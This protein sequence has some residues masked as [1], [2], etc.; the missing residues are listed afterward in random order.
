MKYAIIC[1]VETTGL[2]PAKD[3]VVEV[4]CILYSLEHATPVA[5][6]ASLVHGEGNPAER[7]NRIPS[8]ALTNAPVAQ[9]A[10]NRLSEF[11]DC[12]GD[13][14]VFIAHRAEFDRSF[15]AAVASKL[16][17]R[18]PWVCSKFDIEWPLSKPGASCVEMALAHGVPVVSA[19][20]A[21]T[22]C[23]L[24]AKTIEAVQGLGHDVNAMLE[25][26]LRPKATFQALVSYDDREKA[27]A[28][29]FSWNGAAKVWTRSMAAEDTAALPFPVREVAA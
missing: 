14:A 8:N 15:I 11:I 28:A 9:Y 12:A 26:A 22:D 6:F 23:M 1:D 29:G 10:W 4:G 5:S 2:D 25:R 7:I 20:R 24:V 17:A 21:L 3:R 19:H 13:D 16:S 18:L 27:K